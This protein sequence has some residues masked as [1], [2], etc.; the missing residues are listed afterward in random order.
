ME[1][2]RLTNND[3][4]SFI[5]KGKGSDVE[6]FKYKGIALKLYHD[7]KQLTD[8]EIKRLEFVSSLDVEGITKILGLVEI[9]G[10][11]AGFFS[12]FF[13]GFHF[14]DLMFNPRHE[15]VIFFLKQM[16]NILSNIH[17]KGLVVGD[18]K[19]DNLMFNRLLKTSAI[20]DTK[21]I[22]TEKSYFRFKSDYTDKFRVAD[23]ES[24]IFLFNILTISILERIKDSYIRYHLETHS[25]YRDE[26]LLKIIEWIRTLNLNGYE[27]EYIIDYLPD[28]KKEYKRIK[29]RH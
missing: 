16:R 23:I 17:A 26:K 24:D 13:N 22:V 20:V 2:L 14:S 28:S 11:L 4:I 6:V 21:D 12:E 19:G 7:R 10:E 15:E 27:S 1:I 3:R 29:R 18:I 5:S 9:D 8:D 25:L